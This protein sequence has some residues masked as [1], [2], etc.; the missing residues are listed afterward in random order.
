LGAV[1]IETKG[2]GGRRNCYMTESEEQE[3]MKGFI[4]DA[5]K[6]LIATAAVIHQAFEDNVGQKVHKTT[7]YRMLERTGWRKI[8][9]LPAHPKKNVAAQESFKK[10]LIKS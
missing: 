4:E 9:P 5:R 6:G 7:I 1:S 8:V 3:F 2:K 10:T